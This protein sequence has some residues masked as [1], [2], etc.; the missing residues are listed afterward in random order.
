MRFRTSYMNT[1]NFFSAKISLQIITAQESYAVCLKT[2]NQC[3]V[4][5][6]RYSDNAF[7]V[8]AVCSKQT[9]DLQSLLGQKV[10]H[11]K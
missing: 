1:T 7:P 4:D 6:R 10:T 5:V 8:V 11:A 3:R 2:A 9:N